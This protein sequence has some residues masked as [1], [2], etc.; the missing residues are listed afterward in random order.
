MEE[1]ELVGIV[2]AFEKFENGT[3]RMS[4]FE[5]PWKENILPELQSMC[6]DADL[7]DQKFSINVTPTTASISTDTMDAHVFLKAIKAVKKLNADNGRVTD[8]CVA[9]YENSMAGEDI[10]LAKVRCEPEEIRYQIAEIMS[11]LEKD[12]ALYASAGVY[13]VEAKEHM[14]VAQRYDTIFE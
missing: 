14:I 2:I 7:G 9:F 1:V 8:W 6:D 3:R 5:E 10:S 13:T 12:Y 11:D 4:I